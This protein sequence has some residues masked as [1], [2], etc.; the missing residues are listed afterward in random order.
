VIGWYLVVQTLES[1]VLTP[2]IVGKSLGMHPV[3]VIVALMI[4][5]DLLGFLGLLVA[6]P[7]AAVI[8][9]FAQ[10]LVSRYRESSFYGPPPSGAD[11]P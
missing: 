2:R 7:L 11:A 6:V 1:F 10:D 9:V 4:G 5:G 3:T 8:Q